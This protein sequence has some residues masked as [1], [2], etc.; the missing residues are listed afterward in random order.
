MSTVNATAQCSLRT[1]ADAKGLDA[2]RPG[3]ADARMT[4]VDFSQLR[5]RAGDLVR[6]GDPALLPHPLGGDGQV[7]RRRFDPVTEAD[8]AGEA[9]MRQMISAPSRPT[10]SSAR[11]LAPSGAMPNS[12][13]CST[14]STAP[15]PSSPACPL[16]HPDRPDPQRP[17]GLRH[18]APALHGRA[19]LRR[20]R[21]RRATRA[22]RRAAPA[23]PP[24]RLAR[25]RDPVHHR[26]SSSTGPIC[27]PTTGS[28]AP[29]AS[30]ATATTATPIACWP[31]AISTS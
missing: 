23:H 22:R 6:A 24:L 10:A 21:Q 30:P 26:P 31:P 4:A 12:S 13:G 2:A 15:A 11:N 25:R 1:P 14:R 3:D 7:A 29:A 17:A 8:R 5:P 18:D 27:A 16:G 9:A 28:R 20:R 19:L